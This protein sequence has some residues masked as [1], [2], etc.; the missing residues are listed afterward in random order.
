[1]CVKCLLIF[2]LADLHQD[3][4]GWQA[5]LFIKSTGADGCMVVSQISVMPVILMYL[6][7]YFKEFHDV[8][9]CFTDTSDKVTMDKSQVCTKNELMI[10]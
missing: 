7:D 3:A 1:M 4:D 9:W 10:F 2:Y 8:I 5:S 6:A